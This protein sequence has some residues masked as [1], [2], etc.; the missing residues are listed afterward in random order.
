MRARKGQVALTFDMEHPSRRHHDPLAPTAILDSL[1]N[2]NV[3]ATFFVQGRWARAEPN[4]AARVVNDGHLIGCHSNFHA[5]LVQL[6]DEGIR[7]DVEAASNAIG[8]VTGREP[9]PWFR[10]PFGAGHDDLRVLRVLRD[11]GY[12][13]VHWNVDPQDWLESTTADALIQSVLDGVTQQPNGAV[14]LLHTWPAVTAAALPMLIER[15]AA[16]ERECVG[17]DD[18]ESM[19]IQGKD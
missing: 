16:S 4:L 14:V 19:A 6:T 15:L 8:E 17:I 13:N 3:R 5:P 10:C 2:T 1:R 18:L 9:R 11:C 12:R 7:S